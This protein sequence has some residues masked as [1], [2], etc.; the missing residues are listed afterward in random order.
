MSKVWGLCTC[1]TVFSCLHDAYH[2]LYHVTGLS[3]LCA[4]GDI[5]LQDG[6]NLLEGRVEMCSN[7]QW[8]TDGLQNWLR[9]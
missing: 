1:G 6:Q 8:G 5:R 4:D 9:I 7:Y 3:A 2:E